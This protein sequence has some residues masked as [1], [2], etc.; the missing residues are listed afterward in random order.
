M[1]AMAVDTLAPLSLS[2]TQADLLAKALALKDAPPAAAASSSSTSSSSDS[3][4]KG[5][6][7]G[8]PALNIGAVKD[9]NATADAARVNEA[10]S[11]ADALLKAKRMRNL[12][13]QSLPER[14]LPDSVAD[15]LA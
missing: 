1:W 13:R 7:K 3:A 6:R 11:Q 2:P 15:Q 14:G 8:R 10:E 4:P 12:K 9:A 5:G